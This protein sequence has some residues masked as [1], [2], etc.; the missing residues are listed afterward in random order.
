MGFPALTPHKSAA[1]FVKRPANK[2]KRTP[3]GVEDAQRPSQV[4]IELSAG[5]ATSPWW[6][7]TDL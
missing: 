2:A 5:L 4:T 6:R 3:G 1:D 7:V